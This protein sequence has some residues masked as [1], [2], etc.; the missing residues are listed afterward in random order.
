MFS[1]QSK[2]KTHCSSELRIVPCL[3]GGSRDLVSGLSTDLSFYLYYIYRCVYI[4]ICQYVFK[5]TPI[6][7]SGLKYNLLIL[8]AVMD[9]G[10]F[11]DPVGIEGC[12]R[13]T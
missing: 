13:S 9:M 4:Y 1:P 11:R 7:A 8:R 5:I 10:T 12:G 2:E 6:R 3:R